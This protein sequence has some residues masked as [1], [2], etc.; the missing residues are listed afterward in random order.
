[1]GKEVIEGSSLDDHKM[2]VGSPNFKNIES[3]AAIFTGYCSSKSPFEFIVGGKVGRGV[4]GTPSAIGSEDILSAVTSVEI[5]DSG[6]SKENRSRYLIIDEDRIFPNFFLRAGFDGLPFTYVGMTSPSGTMLRVNCSDWKEAMDIVVFVES[7]N[8]QVIEASVT[9]DPYINEQKVELVNVTSTIDLYVEPIVPIAQEYISP[10][11]SRSK[12]IKGRST[13]SSITF[14]NKRRNNRGPS[15]SSEDVTL[16]QLTVEDEDGFLIPKTI[17]VT[18]SNRIAS[19][20]R[21]LKEGSSNTIRLNESFI[22]E[23]G[24]VNFKLEQLVDDEMDIALHARIGIKYSRCDGEQDESNIKFKDIVDVKAMLHGNEPTLIV[25]GGWFRRATEKYG[26]KNCEWEPILVD[27]I[28]KDP[29]NNYITIGRL[30]YPV[31]AKVMDG[32]NDN[33]SGGLRRLSLIELTKRRDLLRAIPSL[34]EVTISNG[35]RQGRS[36]KLAQSGRRLSGSSKKILVHGFCSDEEAWDSSHFTNSVSFLDPD[37]RRSNN[38]FAI[39]IYQFA[40]RNNINS[41][42]IIAHSQGGL[43]ALHLYENYWSC[44]D[45]AKEGGSKLI[46]SIGSPYQGSPLQGSL[47]AIGGIF[48][49]GCG[50]VEDLTPGGAQAWLS[51]V[52]YEARSQVHYKT[53]S[54]SDRWGWWDACNLASDLL[55]ANPEDGAVEKSRCQLNGGN[56]LGHVVG[57]C[58]TEGMSNPSQTKDRGITRFFDDNAKY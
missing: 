14:F 21:K 26:I 18:S 29:E 25:H 16:V 41:C 27:A 20:S 43:A 42:G 46:Q 24:D 45:E 54:N 38:E 15:S 13:T 6:D 56:N 34:E 5:A 31:S 33:N 19:K 4:I 11:S 2:K 35:M 9:Y 36:P 37:A 49:I 23:N 3:K 44:L 30:K 50:E 51:N 8:S 53:T 55:L 47:A 40:V 52:S 57:F 32:N 12:T 58:H 10:S 17:P 22:D 48:G 7:R 1:V 28:A 39:L